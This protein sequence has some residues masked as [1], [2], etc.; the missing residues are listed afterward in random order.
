[1]MHEESKYRLPVKVNDA[2]VQKDT[3]ILISL[4][5]ERREKENEK[6]QAKRRKPPAAEYIPYGLYPV[7][8]PESSPR[9]IHGTCG[10]E[11]AQQY[12]ERNIMHCERGQGAL[13]RKRIPE[14]DI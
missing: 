12:V 9:E 7:L 2:A 13:E 4:A 6:P 10:T 11:Q 1:M 14:K 8:K 5:V 3:D